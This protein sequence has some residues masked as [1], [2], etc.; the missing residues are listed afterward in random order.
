MPAAAPFESPCCGIFGD[1]TVEA[2]GEFNPDEGVGVPEEVGGFG[3]ESLH[4]GC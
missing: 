1:G 3:G 4:S 2:I